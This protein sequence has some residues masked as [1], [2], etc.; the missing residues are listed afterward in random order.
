MRLDVTYDPTATPESQHTL[1]RIPPSGRV[2]HPDLK[3]SIERYEKARTDE[4][5]ARLTFQQLEIE[6]PAAEYQDELALADARE[7]GKPDPGP[8]NADRQRKAIA[9]AKRQ[10]GARKI[11][12]ARTVEGVTQAF[13]EHGDEWEASLLD[14]S[15][16]LRG[17][18]SDLLSGWEKMYVELQS[19]L[20]NRA[21]GVGMGHKDPAVFARGFKVPRVMDG[22]VVDVGDAIRGLRDLA[23]P[24]P[25][26]EN[27]VENVPIGA[28]PHPFAAAGSQQIPMTRPVP[29]E[30]V[31]AWVE[32]DEAA[33]MSPE[34]RQA[35]LA[36]AER[37]RA[38][39]EATREAVDAEIAEVQG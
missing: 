13:V 10:A 2:D 27:V 20:A 26:K 18:M 11:E 30:V 15:E 4:R 36:R 35:R 6:L 12:L 8:K 19:N 28:T 34:A 21:I 1:K 38:E 25:P 7:Q 24:E 37:V 16:T 31:Q 32:A 33:A 17:A 22:D 39:R 3:S 23:K 9:E 14:E 5:E 29:P